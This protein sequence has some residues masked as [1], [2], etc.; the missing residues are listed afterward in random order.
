MKNVQ[1]VNKHLANLGL[2]NF[3]L[4]N[5]HWN[6]EGGAFVPVHEYI[7][8]V[9]D[10]VFEFYDEVAEQLKMQGESPVVK[11]SE[12]L[13]IASIKEIDAKVF[14][15]SEALCILQDDLKVLQQEAIEIRAVA[16]EE[17]NFALANSMEDELAYYA[18]QLWFIKSSLAN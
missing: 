8:S 7:E 4:H 10:K 13:K 1:S 6:I 11:A 9:Y 14:S 12:Y 2:L 5:L 15:I 18:K 3:K 16:N 17:D